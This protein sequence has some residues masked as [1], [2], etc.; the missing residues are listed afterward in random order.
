MISCW[1]KS[2][3]PEPMDEQR[4]PKR[5]T[6]F[7]RATRMKRILDRLREGWAYDEVGREEGLTERRVRQIVAG[8]LK[9]REAVEGI[10]HAHMQIDR[11]GWAMQVAAKAMAEGD[12][13]AIGPF[14]KAT[15]RLDRYQELARESATREHTSE[16]DRLVMQ[17]LVRR[18][19]GASPSGT[20][21][22]AKAPVA[23]ADG[24]GSAT[25]ASGDSAAGEP[26]AET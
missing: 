3:G 24:A 23:G 20:G 1:Q 26:P 6:Q 22:S 14:I 2:W 9:D 16:G 7:G 17:E 21:L 15:D 13:R 25:G 8:H 11:L 4:R 10:T 12:V 18:I 5:H 19:R